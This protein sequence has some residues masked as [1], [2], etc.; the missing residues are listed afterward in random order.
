MVQ[1]FMDNQVWVGGVGFWRNAPHERNDKKLVDSLQNP[2]HQ[3]KHTQTT[4]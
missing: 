3:F 2:K 1:S 4:R